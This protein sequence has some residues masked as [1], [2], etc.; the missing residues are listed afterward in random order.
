MLMCNLP[1]PCVPK[2]VHDNVAICWHCHYTIP[3]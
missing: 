3:G 2:Y 1:E